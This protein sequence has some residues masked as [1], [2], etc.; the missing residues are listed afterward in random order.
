MDTCLSQLS[1]LKGH[2]EDLVGRNVTCPPVVS[3]CSGITNTPSTASA[4]NDGGWANMT[5]G[6]ASLRASLAEEAVYE[7]QTVVTHYVLE[8]AASFQS[9]ELSAL[10]LMYAIRYA[11]GFRFLSLVLLSLL[12]SR[13]VPML[14]LGLFLFT[15]AGKVLER[16]RQYMRSTRFGRLCLR[17]CAREDDPAVADVPIVVVSGPPVA[18]PQPEEHEARVA[19][20]LELDRLD[21]AIRDLRAEREAVLQR[22]EESFGSAWLIAAGLIASPVAVSDEIQPAVQAPS[23]YSF[24]TSPLGWLGLTRRSP[25]L[26]TEL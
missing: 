18:D 20:H 26:V 13:T 15:E 22:Y 17:F 23:L 6:L 19:L 2:V 24:V 14:W 1:V 5:Y 16:T 4:A 9:V 3:N 11:S 7:R 12:F 25:D 10:I 8:A 21:S